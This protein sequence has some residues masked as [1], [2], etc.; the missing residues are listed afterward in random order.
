MDKG[1]ETVRTV[2][3]WI[4]INPS[5]LT[6]R[7][8][9]IFPWASLSPNPGASH[10]DRGLGS[11]RLRGLSV[12]LEGVRRGTG[13]G[14]RLSEPSHLLSVLFCWR[15]MYAWAG[16]ASMGSKLSSSRGEEGIST[17]FGGSIAEKARRGKRE[18]V[19][20]RVGY[21]DFVW[22]TILTGPIAERT[23]R[24]GRLL[25]GLPRLSR[26]GL[27]FLLGTPALTIRSNLRI[28]G[29]EGGGEDN[30]SVRERATDSGE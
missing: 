17:M 22:E 11:L 28:V 2:R 27:V 30:L 9:K 3:W 12:C 15:F 5:S 8:G 26:P 23:G 13:L 25:E 1:V 10:L 19:P 18:S 7:Q 29:E 24:L 21:A 20:S 6:R 14:R 4:L 16:E